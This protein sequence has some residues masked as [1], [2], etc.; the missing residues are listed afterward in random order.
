MLRLEKEVE[1]LHVKSD[2]CIGKLTAY[3]GN[4]LNIK[5]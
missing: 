5:A 2:Y 3:V 4:V 1:L